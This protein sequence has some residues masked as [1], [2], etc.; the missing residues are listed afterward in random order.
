MKVIVYVEGKGDRLCLETLLRPL[1]KA[2]EAAGVLIQFV[3]MQRGDRKA[4]LLTKAPQKAALA[5]LNDPQNCVVILPDLYPPNKGFDHRTCE[6]LQAGVLRNFNHEIARR[7]GSDDRLTARFRVFCLIH[8]LE[9]LLLAAE[10]HFLSD[11]GLSAVTWT[12]PVEEQD[13]EN[14]PKRIVEKLIRNYQ[15]T[16]DGPRVLERADY[17]LIRERCPRGFGQFV[18]FLET[19]H[20]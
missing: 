11:C 15:P 8:D 16:V 1:L 5:I 14:P 4:T 2:K 7:Q 9:V 17:Q 18:A 10:E 3:E 6:E 20:A 12:R 19:V 13:Q